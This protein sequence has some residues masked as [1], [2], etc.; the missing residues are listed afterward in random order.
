MLQF[1]DGKFC[2]QGLSFV[3]PNGFYL[4]TEPEAVDENVVVAWAPDMRYRIEWQI[5]EAKRSTIEDFE[6][7]IRYSEFAWLGELTPVALNGLAG[8]QLYYKSREEDYYELRLSNGKS[9]IMFYI[10]AHCGDIYKITSSPE[11]KTIISNLRA[12]VPA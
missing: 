7:L 2:A 5:Y 4:D 1:K 12:C 10:K 11:I 8:H 9:S 6:H 3:F